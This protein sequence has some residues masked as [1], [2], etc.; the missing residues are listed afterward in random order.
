MKSFKRIKKVLEQ[1]L[2]RRKFLKETIS[3]SGCQSLTKD[4][5]INREENFLLFFKNLIYGYNRNP[6]LELLKLSGIG[7][8]D[9][10]KM[11]SQEG[12]EGYKYGRLR[13]EFS[14]VFGLGVGAFGYLNHCIYNN[15]KSIN[16]YIKAVK[17][18]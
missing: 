9:I 8:Q 16:A 15:L 12:I 13:A 1:A 7:Y 14:D 5:M 3:L 6:Y 10:E 11:V 18:T 4:A 17:A 2:N